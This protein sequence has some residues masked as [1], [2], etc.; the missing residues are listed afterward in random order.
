M[1]YV[2]LW[3]QQ[4]LL[5]D[6]QVVNHLAYINKLTPEQIS[7]LV[8]VSGKSLN[9]LVDIWRT[10][11]NDAAQ[12]FL[13]ALVDQFKIL[14]NPNNSIL[15][16]FLNANLGIPKAGGGAAAPPYAAPNAPNPSTN[17]QGPPNPNVPGA[18]PGHPDTSPTGT[19]V[20]DASDFG[21]G[22]ELSGTGDQPWAKYVADP[23]WNVAYFDPG[24]GNQYGLAQ[25]YSAV[26]GAMVGYYTKNQ[27]G[28]WAW[29][30]NGGATPPPVTVS[31]IPYRHSGGLAYDEGMF[32]LQQGEFV[33]SRKAVNS[34]G[35]DYVRSLNRY[36]DG[37][38]VRPIASGTSGPTQITHIYHTF[39]PITVVA[40]DGKKMIESIQAKARI[41]KMAGGV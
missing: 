32:V 11:G 29:T 15:D 38:M 2:K 5:I 33:L 39:G 7:E 12:A 25:I 30:G 4:T 24:H 13:Q 31:N 36:H 28:N 21:I 6:Q 19:G 26:Y 3:K 16:I 10:K 35:Q 22:R 8:R 9:E 14:N 1:E 17:V 34:L 41:A 20:P 18:A 37:G 40:N 27:D 23:A